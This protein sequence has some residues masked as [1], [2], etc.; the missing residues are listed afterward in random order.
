M[1][2]A[3]FVNKGV[4]K[5]TYDTRVIINPSRGIAK[6]QVGDM[7]SDITFNFNFATEE[8]TISGEIG[9]YSNNYLSAVVGCILK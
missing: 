8:V 2:T 5:D 7:D 1:V 9:N 4:V 6:V 3:H